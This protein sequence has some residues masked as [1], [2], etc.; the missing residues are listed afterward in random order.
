MI[1]D[2]KA[3]DCIQT[4]KD[5]CKEQTSCENCIF[6]EFGSDHWNCLIGSLKMQF[7]LDDANGAYQAKKKHRGYIT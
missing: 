5:F 4:L 7:I 3:L 1:S 6:R 2:K